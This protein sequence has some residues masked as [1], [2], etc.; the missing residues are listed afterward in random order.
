MHT[1]IHTYTQ[2]VA[3]KNVADIYG[4]QAAVLLAD[5]DEILNI[6]IQRYELGIQ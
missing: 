3:V 4:P 2:R 6:V 5:R 1:H